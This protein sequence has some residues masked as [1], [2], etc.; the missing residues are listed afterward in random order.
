VLL[1]E[2]LGS[3]FGEGGHQTLAPLVLPVPARL[4][5]H[6]KGGLQVNPVLHW[7]MFS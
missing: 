6:K 3:G 4:E 2:D 5:K 1:P 7:F